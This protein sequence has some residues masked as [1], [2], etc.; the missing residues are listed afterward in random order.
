MSYQLSVGEVSG[1][2]GTKEEEVRENRKAELTGK[3]MGRE[4]EQAGRLGTFGRVGSEGVCCDGGK[5]NISVGEGVVELV[6]SYSA[7]IELR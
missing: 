2:D 1:R 7:A 5:V 6:P 4:D 3:R